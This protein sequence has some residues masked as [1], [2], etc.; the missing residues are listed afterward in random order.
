MCNFF[1]GICLKDKT[2]LWEEGLDS[3]D[4]I[5]T[6]FEVPD[7]TDRPDL[8]K[9]FRFEITPPVNENSVFEKDRSHWNFRIDERIRPEWVSPAHEEACQQALRN[10]L[11]ACV[12]DGAQIEELRD[13]KGIYL[14]NTTVD[15]LMGSTEIVAMHGSSTVQDMWD[16][17][18]VQNMRGDRKSV[19]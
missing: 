3:H 17:S 14:R 9:F 5:L 16:S 15:R 10:C 2:V 19:V 12:F 18:T 11:A 6:K 13:R 1:S 4:E 8:M 7:N